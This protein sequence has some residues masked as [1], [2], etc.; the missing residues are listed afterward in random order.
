MNNSNIPN[1]S[2]RL[3]HFFLRDEYLEEIEGDM[4]EIFL[5][6]SEKYSI[7][8]ARRIY[9]REVIKLIRPNLLK[10]WTGNQKLNNIGMLQ[11][12]LKLTLRGYSRYKSSFLINLIGLAS[13]LTCTLL[14]YLWVND[15]YQVDQFHEKNHSLYQ[16]LANSETSNGILTDRATPGQLAESLAEELPEV[17]LAVTKTW[18]NTYTLS[19]EEASLKAIGQYATKEYFNAFSYELLQGDKNEVLV[20]QA[21]IVISDDLAIR[22]FGTTTDVVGKTIKFQQFRDYRV[23]G[24]FKSPPP[25]STQQFDFIMTYEEFKEL[26]SWV[27]N[28]RN[29][30][31]STFVVLAEGARLEDFNTK[32]KDFVRDHGGEENITPIATLYSDLYLHGKYENGKSVGGRISNVRLFIL[33][34]LFVLGIACINFMNLATARVS[35][36]MKEIGIKK[37]VGAS[38]RSLAGQFLSESLLMASLSLVLALIIALLVLPTFN[39]ITG[40]ELTLTFS[41]EFV[42]ILLTTLLFTGLLA[43]SYP[44]VYLSAIKPIKV[45]KSQATG[46]VRELWLRKGLVVFQF[47]ISIILIVSVLVINNQIQYTQEKDIGFN[48]DNV[49]YFE[50]E[51]QIELNIESF[52]TEVNKLPGVKAVSSSAHS[53]VEGGY[54]GLTFDVD[55]EGKDPN[56]T[57]GME[58][59]RVNY[60]MIELLELEITSGRAFSRDFKTDYNKVIFNEEAISQM[61]LD[62][63]IGSTVKIGRTNTQIVGVVKDFHFKSFH[64]SVGP[65]YF[66]LQP[67]D[68]WLIMARLE[69]GSERETISRLGELYDEF[70]PDF[71]FDYKFLDQDYQAQYVSEQRVATLSKYFSLIAILISCLG[72]L[73]LASFS[74]ERRIKEIGIRKVLGSSQFAI[75][76]LVSGEFTKIVMAAVVLSLPISYFVTKSWLDGFA[77]RIDLSL[78]FFLIAGASALLIAWITVGFQTLKASMINP[79]QCLR[80][81]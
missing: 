63:P 32:I 23:S 15:E 52:I 58:Y 78:W 35:R 10:R 50:A 41:L 74:T 18:T 38:R 60:D 1:W 68:T 30:G 8:K 62:N 17:E 77:Y 49:L 46:A 72:L 48:R 66:V 34:A 69:Q 13:G 19:Y 33:I 76:K 71:S 39:V 11:H 61:N 65:A 36:R 67:D 47:T 59:M 56:A 73:G 4:G 57:V 27:L 44:A 2:N 31:P 25:S 9:S 6:N 40:K 20:E 29:N 3:L 22:L 54:S 7:R 51:G 53:F 64:E 5:E 45:L 43:G 14:I 75:V 79:A 24:V 70:N 37:T 12:N 16:V 26:N 80:N 28:W 81:E 42:L 55:W 21:N